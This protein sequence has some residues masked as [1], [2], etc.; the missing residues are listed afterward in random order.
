MA[1]WVQVWE[2]DQGLQWDHPGPNHPIQKIL[3]YFSPLDDW[4]SL[5]NLGDIRIIFILPVLECFPLN[6]KIAHDLIPLDVCCSEVSLTEFRQPIQVQSHLEMPRILVQLGHTQRT[7]KLAPQTD[8]K[9]S[10][11]RSSTR[12]QDQMSVKCTRRTL[13]MPSFTRAPH[14]QPSKSSF[15]RRD[16]DFGEPTRSRGTT[17]LEQNFPASPQNQKT[18]LTHRSL[19]MSLR[20]ISTPH[21]N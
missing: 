4:Q 17:R 19:Y 18:K 9:W 2:Q 10:P 6:F 20:T 14:A 21:V 5:G 8:H 7:W 12:Y 3:E 13:R 11:T 16:S 15:T 1:G